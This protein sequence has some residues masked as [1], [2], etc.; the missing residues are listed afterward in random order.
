MGCYGKQGRGPLG[1]VLSFHEFTLVVLH[2]GLYYI[3]LLLYGIIITCISQCFVPAWGHSC[4]KL[5]LKVLGYIKTE[6]F[7]APGAQKASAFLNI[8]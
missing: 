1:G 3:G 7:R 5:A 8:T 4:A 6:R 2:L